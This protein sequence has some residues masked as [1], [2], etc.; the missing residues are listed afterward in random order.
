[1]YFLSDFSDQGNPSAAN[2]SISQRKEEE[3][4]Q[5][6]EQQSDAQQVQHRKHSTQDK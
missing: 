3:E 1:M 6:Q 2:A 4:E 5:Q